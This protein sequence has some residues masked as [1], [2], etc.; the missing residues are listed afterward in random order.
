MCISH[1]LFMH[2]TQS[3]HAHTFATLVMPWS[4]SYFLILSMLCLLYVLQNFVFKVFC[5]L[6]ELYFSFILHPSCII[7]LVHIFFSFPPSF[8]SICLFVTKRGRVLSFL[9]DSCAHSQEEKFYLMHIR[10]GRNSIGEMH[11]LRE[12]RHLCMR[13]PCFICFTLCLFSCLLWC[14][15]LCLVSIL[16]CSYRIVFM[17]WTCIHSYAIVLY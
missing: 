7:T 8:L 10:R 9:Y 6:F 1:A 12:R 13:K 2:C 5:L 17:C 16:C 15:E 14:F 4:I 3:S 11:I